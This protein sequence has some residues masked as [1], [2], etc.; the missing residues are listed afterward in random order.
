M[1]DMPSALGQAGRGWR[2][3]CGVALLVLAIALVLAIP[4]LA[5]F[6]LPP[7][8]LAAITGAVFIINKLLLILIIALVGKAGFQELKNILASYVPHVK[9]VGPIGPVRHATGLAMFWIPLTWSVLEPYI[10]YFWP[11]LRPN[12][13]AYQLG[14]DLIFVA[15]IFVL[16]GNFWEKVQALF[17]RTARVVD[18]SSH[19]IE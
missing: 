3:K 19:R 12:K 11:G 5:A 18:T 9:K 2:F 17:I 7:A 15:G 8:T 4:L 16:G 14:G 10:D 13:W 6:G 1:A